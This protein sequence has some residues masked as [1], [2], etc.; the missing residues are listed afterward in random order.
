M[1]SLSCD[2][3]RIKNTQVLEHGNSWGNVNLKRPYIRTNKRILSREDELLK[4]KKKK[5]AVVYDILLKESGGPFQPRSL[6]SESRDTK[7]ILNRQ[8]MLLEKEKTNSECYKSINMLDEIIL[9]Q[10]N[11]HNLVRTVTITDNT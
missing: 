1:Y 3:E 6:S 10:R 9:A 2:E 7:K 8:A 5:T 4:S 11:P